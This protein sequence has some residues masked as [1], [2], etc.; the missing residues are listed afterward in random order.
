MSDGVKE[1]IA[2][3][4]QHPKFVKAT[5]TTI[6]DQVKLIGIKVEHIQRQEAVLNLLQGIAASGTVVFVNTRAAADQLSALLQ[7]KGLVA[8][9]LHGGM[10]Q[11]DRDKAMTLFRNGTTQILVATDVAAR[12]LDIDALRHIVHFELPIDAAA[13][14]H[15]SG[16][17]GRAGRAAPCTPLLPPETSRSCATGNCST[18]TNG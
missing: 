17:T 13:Y 10:E 16:R 7:A 14:L 1:L 15:R 4:L 9:T 11:P 8:R 6:P 18:W 3:S 12:G 2:D 5:A